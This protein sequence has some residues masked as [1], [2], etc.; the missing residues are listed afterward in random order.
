MNVFKKLSITAKIMLPVIG[1]TILLIITGVTSLLVMQTMQDSSDEISGNYAQSI[2]QLGDMNV[3][4]E[5]LKRIAFAHCISESETEQKVLEE[6]AETLKKEIT[7]ISV[8]FEKTLDAGAEMDAYKQ[9][10]EVY[11]DFKES[12]EKVLDLSF[13][14]M[15]EEAVQIVNRELT[16]KGKEMST[17]MSQM[18]EANKDGMEEAILQDEAAFEF[19]RTTVFVLIVVSV[20]IAVLGII[21]TMVSVIRPIKKSTKRIQKIVANIE[22]AK[23]DLTMRVDVT[24]EDE[25]GQMCKDVNALIE[26]LQKIMGYIAHDT[27]SLNE[28]VTQVSGSVTEVNASACDVSAVMEEL[29][30]T[31]EEVSATAVNVNENTEQVAGNVGELSSASEELARYAGEMKERAESLEENA[32]QNKTDTEQVVSQIVEALERAVEDS[33]SVERVNELTGEILSISSQTNLLALNASI[34]AARAGDAGRG[35]AVV[36]DEIRQLA[37]S[38]RETA[39]NIQNI[40]NMVMHAV[41]ELVHNANE[42]IG[43]IKDS[44]MPAY[45]DFVSGGTRYKNDAVHIDETVARFSEMAV[46]IDG[47][48]NSIRESING[49]SDSVGQSAEAITTAATNTNVLVKEIEQINVEMGKNGDIAQEL[50]SQ[51]DSFEKL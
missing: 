27:D 39:S 21:T 13:K 37:D 8:E 15:D 10:E 16:N 38:S 1:L 5:A 23:G 44:V 26:A 46:H 4:F 18:V 19:A 12:M 14:G 29:S 20:V 31:M 25:V 7:A 9:L 50:Q 28:I 22:D 45:D 47:L 11:G 6:E 33:K 49:I 41:K 42:M 43:Y 40:N 48:T 34:E 30:A 35:F 24:S 51:V 32:I 2:L 36:A 17:L 3:K